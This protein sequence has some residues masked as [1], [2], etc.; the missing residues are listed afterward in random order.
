MST[1]AQCT[2]LAEVRQ[3]VDRV[4]RRLVALIAE[5][6]AYVRQAAA[7]KNT[8]AEV[9]APQRGAQEL[10][11]IKALALE[12]GAFIDCKRQLQAAF[13]PPSPQPN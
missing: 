7:F 10:A 12:N 3:H 2:S 6:G 5:R 4:D 1:I 9:P 8:A 13:H 11:K